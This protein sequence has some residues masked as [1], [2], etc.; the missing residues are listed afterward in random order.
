MSN[1]T[2]VAERYHEQRPVFSSLAEIAATTLSALLRSRKVDFLA[3]SHR[4]KTLESVIEKVTRKDYAD[5]SEMTDIAGIRVITYIESDVTRAA[6]LVGTAFL[7][8]TDKSVDKSEELSDDRFGYRSVHFVCELGDARIALPELAPFKGL[9]FEVQVRTV[10]QHAWAEIEHDRSY[11]FSGELPSVIRR[12]LN[13]LAGVLELA[14]GEFGLLA[15]EV[16][17]YTKRVQ[18]SAKS[19]SLGEEELT[20]LS[21][22]EYL[23]SGIDLPIATGQFSAKST[24]VEDVIGELKLFGV[25]TV[26]G[27]KHLLTA[28]FLAALMRHVPSTTV[29]GTF[30]RAMLFTDMERYFS[31]AW[32][33]RWQGMSPETYGLL[34]ERYGEATCCGQVISDTTIGSCAAIFR[35]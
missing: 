1:E 12:R 3:V 20:S 6:E 21:L 16:D 11:K 15:Y 17:E 26:S 7:V 35:S 23:K 18:Q 4:T 9:T 31:Q 33:K 5:L 8:H 32:M 22:L 24:V 19:G 13:L 27:I 34:S 28:D 25:D 2:E 29:V 30:R 14:D 10:L